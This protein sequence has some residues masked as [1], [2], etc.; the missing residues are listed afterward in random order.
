MVC[1]GVKR[2][3]L[4]VRFHKVP[5]YSSEGMIMSQKAVITIALLLCAW[6]AF[7]S[8]QRHGAGNP[9][10]SGQLSVS[11]AELETDYGQS[12]KVTSRVSMKGFKQ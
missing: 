6:C 10:V 7:K 5:V 4:V 2:A 9:V 1:P 8:I 3:R 12:G 11:G